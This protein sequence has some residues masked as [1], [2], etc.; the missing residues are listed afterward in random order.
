MKFSVSWL[1]DY[2]EFD[3]NI[4]ELC[5]KLTAIGLEVENVED[6][7]KSLAAFE[8]AKIIEA[9]KH[10]NSEKLSVCKVE[11]AS[12]EIL[13]IV[14][15]A[16]NAR[17]GIKVALAPIG[18]VIPSNQ[19]VIKKA[20]I[21][22]VE[23]CGMMCSAS[24]LALG[25][26]GEGIIEIDEK[27]PLGEKI[28]K[29]YGK[30]DAIIEIN[31]TPNRGDCLG[32]YGI[33]KDLAAADFGALKNL[34]IKKNS[35]VISDKISAKISALDACGVAAFRLIKDVKNCESPL[36]LKEKLAS[37]GQASISAVVDVTNYVMFCLNR[38]MHAYDAS[39]IN[40]AVDV[41]YAKN[42][43]KFLSLKK[44]EY[45]LDEKILVVADDANVLGIAGVI[46]SL[47]SSCNLQTQDILL[48]A[49]FFDKVAVALSGRRLN[50]LSDARYRFERGVDYKNC[51]A[52]IELA[53]ALIVEI[54]GGKASE[55]VVVESEN[56]K[57][58]AK[59]IE[60]N[61]EKIAKLTGV[62]VADDKALEI[63]TKLE[64][65][66][67]K[68]E[69]KKYL[70]EVP[71]SRSDVEIAADLVEEVVRIYGYDK[72]IP[73]KLEITPLKLN[74][75]IFDKVRQNLLA[76]GMVENINW[77]FCDANLVKEFA[78][79]KENLTL[80]NPIAEQLAH[81]RPNLIIGLM[82]SYQKNYLRS[83]SD[84]SFFEIGKVFLGTKENEQK[85][86][87][88]GLR[89][90]KNNE[91]NHYNDCRDF[92]IFDVKKDIFNCLEIFGLKASS[93]QI[94]D[95]EAPK[96]YHPHR[97]AALKLGKNIVGYFGEIHPKIAKIFD[98]KTSVN[99]FEIFSDSL[100]QAAF[101][102]KSVQ[103]KSFEA[104]DLQS[105]WRD[106]AFLLE[107]DKKIGDLTKT[108]ENCD[109]NLIKQVDIFDIYAGKNIEEGKKSVALRVMIQPLE[110]S[111]T[112][113]EIDVI[114]KKIIDAVV[115]AHK[116]VLRG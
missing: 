18:A 25:V 71:S 15:G 51:E 23:S 83:F 24:E 16:K 44:E 116:A 99:I 37:I 52:G 110:K 54:C 66:C 85:Q 89:A 34:E 79:V 115:S 12:G 58:N 50:I 13:Q 102:G 26:D 63:L 106:F 96:Y 108:I 77:S 59:K 61:L 33:A 100:P 7:A 2:L 65:V 22:G 75:D 8:V 29:I 53:T 104:S 20:K 36:W 11:T 3:A 31:V 98:V 80:A 90:G 27:W 40:G 67:K 91:Q 17:A 10:E 111:L 48:E 93:V 97:S 76:G 55:V 81:M 86:M 113:E 38:P 46:G 74:T 112:G 30:N 6:E 69:G 1:R 72:I 68:I 39:K 57:K 94:S 95:N 43:E 41:R 32:V 62:E 4:E 9:V 103:K 47:D 14:C 21:A 45:V 60:F 88:A 5:K 78:E 28:A 114:S 42:G 101:E 35:A 87:I 82:Q 109:K 70:V 56:F 64:F 49:A 107:A 84:V 92:D 19:L 105:V 73:K